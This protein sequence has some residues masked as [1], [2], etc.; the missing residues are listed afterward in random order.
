MVDC[1]VQCTMTVQCDAST[2]TVPVDGSCV[3]FEPLDEMFLRRLA[4]RLNIDR[5]A[6]MHASEDVF[7]EF[8]RTREWTSNGD[9]D[10][11][12][13]EFGPSPFDDSLLLEFERDDLYPLAEEGSDSIESV[14]SASSPS[15]YGDW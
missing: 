7:A 4:A 15:V 8:E 2:N 12:Q 3:H 6:L 10:A 13:P 9:A 14:V 1:G 5:A 11:D